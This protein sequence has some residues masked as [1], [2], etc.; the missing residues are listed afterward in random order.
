MK[1]LVV[2][3]DSLRLDH[4]DYMTATQ[5]QFGESYDRAFAVATATAGAFPQMMS[6]RYD[7]QHDVEDTDTWMH[8]I[9]DPTCFITTNRLVS[10]RYGYDDGVTQF[11]SPISRGDESVKDRIAE[12]VPQGTVYEVLAKAWSFW[13][14]ATPDTKKSFRT[15]E[16]VIKEFRDWKQDKQDWCAV[17]HL[18]EPHH[19]YDPEDTDH[20]RAQAQAISRDAIATETPS[21][22]NDVRE[23]YKH[24]VKEVDA[25][26]ERLWDIIDDETQVI[27]TADHGEMLGEDGIWGHPGQTFHPSILRIPWVTQ[28]VDIKGDVVSFIDIPAFLLR[29][30]W[31]EAQ[32]DREVAYASMGELKYVFDNDWM[33]TENDTFRLSDGNKSRADELR[34]RL[35]RFDPSGISKQSGTREDLRALGYLD[36]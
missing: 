4:Y 26:L 16:S 12:R 20:S 27:L 25:Q 18:M 6:G 24:E 10:E 33:I 15:A 14:K 7:A 28:N 9:N 21:R 2:I 3:V 31:R 35:E 29:Q 1:R 36:E 22:P 34:S 5:A 32:L 17:L 13:Q 30:D 23:L 11:S 8:E 19:P